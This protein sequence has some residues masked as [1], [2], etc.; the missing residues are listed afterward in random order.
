[1]VAARFFRSAP[2]QKVLSWV[3]DRISE[4]PE[5]RAVVLSGQGKTFCAGAD[6]K[7]RAATIKGPGDVYKRQVVSLVFFCEV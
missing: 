6:L 3:L 5:V 2:A 4:T 7:N 1:M